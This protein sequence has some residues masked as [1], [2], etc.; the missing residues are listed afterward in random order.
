MIVLF[1]S[2]DYLSGVHQLSSIDSFSLSFFLIG[3][4]QIIFKLFQ[5]EGLIAIMSLL[6]IEFFV[7]M[8][9]A[10]GCHKKLTQKSQ[11]LY[12]TLSSHVFKQLMLSLHESIQPLIDWAGQAQ[13]DC[14]K[15]QKI[16]LK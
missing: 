9:L 2:Q 8:Q 14:E 6:L 3:C 5:P 16:V 10:S 13:R 1:L 4:L 15:L 7:C 11:G 12:H